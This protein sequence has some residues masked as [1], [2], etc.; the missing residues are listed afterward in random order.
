VWLA[1]FLCRVIDDYLPLAEAVR[2][3]AD[4]ARI[5]RW[6]AARQQVALAI[7]QAGWDCAWYRRAFF[8]DGSP[9]GSATN[10]ECRIDLIAQAWAVLSGAGDPAR[11]AQAMDSARALLWDPRTRLMRLLDP[12][13]AQAQ[14][15]AGYIQAY[16]PGIR[17]N[18]GQY[19][20]AAV[21]ALMASA[22]QGDADWAWRLFEALSPAHRSA[23]PVLGPVYALEP[24]VLAGD[25]YSRPPCA[26]RG[27]WSWYTGAA[28]WLQRAALE[29]ICGLHQA[30][31]QLRLL[32][33]VPPHWPRVDIQLAQGGHRITLLRDAQ[34][35][36]ELLSRQPA[37]QLQRGQIIDLASLPPGSVLVL[38][39]DAAEDG[40]LAHQRDRELSAAGLGDAG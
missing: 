33:C 36:R 14:P 4:P 19:N 13:L 22:Q 8:D 32:P 25:I 35:L 17:E 24:Y 2:G 15:D 30:G 1:W 28:S 27:G 20:H 23:D 11:A 31:N 38:L 6:R 16:P 39:L 12:P 29:S 18:G 7:E 10:S 34:A 5:A 3:E 37:I 21:W 26:G 40:S 9:L